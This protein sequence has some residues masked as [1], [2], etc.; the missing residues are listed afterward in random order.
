M[1]DD[2]KGK[3]QQQPAKT[4]STPDQATSD[5]CI[6]VRRINSTSH[7]KTLEDDEETKQTDSKV[8]K[9]DSKQKKTAAPKK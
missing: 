7:F 2:E 4:P 1:Q 3:K 9:T 5:D 8:K 6:Q